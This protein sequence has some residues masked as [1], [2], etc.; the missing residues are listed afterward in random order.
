MKL[1]SFSFKTSAIL[2]LLSSVLL[3]G[4]STVYA[5]ESCQLIQIRLEKAGGGSNI[6]I[7]P[8]AITV[9]V[10]TCTVWINFVRRQKVLVSFRD[11]VK[12]CI[13]ATDPLTG[14]T[15]VKLKTGESCYLSET[16]PRGKTAS[17]VWSKPGIYKYTLEVPATIGSVFDTTNVLAE[18]VIE[19][20]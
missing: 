14:F 15:E 10:G 7:F 2:F 18:G 6:E 19:V 12:Q 1:K 17:L 8:E 20:K 9:P 5:E 13:M 16:L 3:L 4:T 11:N